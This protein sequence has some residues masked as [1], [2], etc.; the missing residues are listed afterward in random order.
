M[1]LKPLNK[2]VAAEFVAKRHYSAVMPKLTKYYLGC[3]IQ[4]ELVGVITFGWGTRPKHTI[5]KF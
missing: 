1:F 2:Y 3:F 5:Q 4:D